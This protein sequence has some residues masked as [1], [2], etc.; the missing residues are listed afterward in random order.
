MIPVGMIKILG[1]SC[2][3]CRMGI[4]KTCLREGS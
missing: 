4:I 3:I 2:F 1:L